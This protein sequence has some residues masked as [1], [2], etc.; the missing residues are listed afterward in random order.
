MIMKSYRAFLLL[1]VLSVLTGC[2]VLSSDKNED[3]SVAVIELKST[4][5]IN[6]DIRGHASP[7]TVR[8][9][10]L[11]STNQ[12]KKS[13]FFELYDSEESAL[14]TELVSRQEFT[15]TPEDVLRKT[16]VLSPTT[17]YLGV[18]AAFSDIDNAKWRAISPVLPGEVLYNVV[19][20]ERVVEFK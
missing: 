11:T 14:G 9:Y 16:V 15:V 5:L 18:V 2:S 7:L 4:G 10:E 19:L 20:D 8:I 17:K 12:F 1:A 13:G 6:P 3:V